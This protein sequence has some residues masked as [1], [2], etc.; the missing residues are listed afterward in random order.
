METNQMEAEA[1]ECTI[2]PSLVAKQAI[3][4]PHRG[5]EGC[6]ITA[7][8]AGVFF[9]YAGEMNSGMKFSLEEW[10]QVVDF[11]D[12][13]IMAAH[14]DWVDWAQVPAKY[15]YVAADRDGQVYGYSIKPEPDTNKYYEW[16][17]QDGA[18]G[19]NERLYG[20]TLPAETTWEESL[21][22]RP[23]KYAE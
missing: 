8:K 1:K 14:E 6:V 21:R 10:N 15:I 12:S 13:Q 2:R 16:F 23:G 5:R 11:V 22:K 19:A 9:A 7:G 4:S 20:L 3:V 18:V 17:L